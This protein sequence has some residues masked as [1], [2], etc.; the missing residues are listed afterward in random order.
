MLKPKT[1]NTQIDNIQNNILI[2]KSRR[3]IVKI[4]C[5][6]YYWHLNNNSTRMPKAITAWENIQSNF[7][8]KITALGKLSL[9]CPSSVSPT[10]Q[11][12]HSNIK[13]YTEYYLAMSG[14]KL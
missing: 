9:K 4:N 8:L 1:Y 5:K 3:E 12:N 14:S 6:D 13:L 11:Y 2:K 7:N 10:L